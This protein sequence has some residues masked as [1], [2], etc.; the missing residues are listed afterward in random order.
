MKNPLRLSRGLLVALAATTLASCSL[1]RVALRD[2]TQSQALELAIDNAARE[3]MAHVSTIVGT[4]RQLARAE[5]RLDID[6]IDRLTIE[7]AQE[8]ITYAQ[9]VRSEQAL[10]NQL[11]LVHRSS[12]H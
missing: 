4:Q 6:E 3:R 7:A 1:P 12:R 9:L 2:A 8:Q 5:D 10:R 11:A